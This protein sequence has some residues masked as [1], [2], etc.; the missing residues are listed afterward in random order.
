ML[1]WFRSLQCGSQLLVK[2]G[3]GERRLLRLPVHRNMRP[4]PRQTEPAVARTRFRI[5]ARTMG[6]QWKDYLETE[7]PVHGLGLCE[8]RTRATSMGSFPVPEPEVSGRMTASWEVRVQNC[9]R[10]YHFNVFISPG[11]KT[12]RKNFGLGPSTS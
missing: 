1:D 11:E 2:Q 6:W 12:K 9:T 10:S 4:L 8:D 5:S 7:V 3:F